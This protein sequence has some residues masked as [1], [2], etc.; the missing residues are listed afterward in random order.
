MAESMFA[1]DIIRCDICPADVE[2]GAAEIFCKSCK[3]HLCQSCISKHVLSS[4]VDHIVVQYVAHRRVRRLISPTVI[5]T[6]KSGFIPSSRVVKSRDGSLWT[7]GDMNTVKHLDMNGVVME[8]YSSGSIHSPYHIT[9]KKGGELVFTVMAGKVLNAIMDKQIKT[10]ITFREWTPRGLCVTANDD[11][12]VSMFRTKEPDKIVRY[13]GVTV[14]QEISRDSQ[15]NFLFRDASFV[16]ENTNT[17]VCVSD[18]EARC[19]VVVKNTGVPR[20]KY[21]GGSQLEFDPGCVACDSQSHILIADKYQHCVHII[22][23]DGKFLS[24]IDKHF[25]KVPVGIHVGEDDTLYVAE[26][27]SGK[28]KVIKYMSP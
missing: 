8:T 18:A 28:I 7:L 14:I 2:K 27:K 6:L 10:I 9:Q 26:R 20:Y 12:L 16:C 24:L 21:S 1:Q 23:K 3:K 22:D 25:V 11:V 15:G 13:S 17:D 19:V 4:T 5:Q